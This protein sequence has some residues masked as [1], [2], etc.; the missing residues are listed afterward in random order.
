MNTNNLDILEAQLAPTFVLEAPKLLETQEIAILMS[1]AR[2]DGIDL[3]AEASR[4]TP[5]W[6]SYPLGLWRCRAYLGRSITVVR[7]I[8]H[9]ALAKKK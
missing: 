5:V 7:R 6:V 3:L 1:D 9:Q 8:P 4:S 2:D